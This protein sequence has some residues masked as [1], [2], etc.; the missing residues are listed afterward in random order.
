MD[1]HTPG[2]VDREGWQYA[3]DFPATYH[4]KKQFTDYVRRRRWYRKCRLTT[5]G[6]WHELGNSKICDVSLQ[7][8]GPS[9]SGGS[10]DGAADDDSRPISVWAIAG[11]GDALWR[12]GCTPATPAG[13]S[14]DHV[15]SH[16]PL[17]SISCAAENR[18]WVVSKTGTAFVRYGVT[19]DQPQGEAWQPVE[20]PSGTT[21]KQIS[22]GRMGVW[23]LDSHGRLVVRREVTTAFPEGTHWTVLANVQ[24]DGPHTE[25]PAPGATIGFKAVSVGTEVWAIANSGQLCRRAGIT[26]DNPAGTGW[27]LG[28]PVSRCSWVGQHFSNI[29][30]YADNSLINLFS[31]NPIFMM[32]CFVI[33]VLTGKLP[34]CVGERTGLGRIGF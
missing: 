3:I 7:P 12:R 28:I 15:A 6:P 26:S 13:L 32:F 2:G 20:P 17:V 27:L 14:W 9:G 31:A 18:V 24:G 1:F 8:L 10:G 21:L 33:N 16:Q 25:V 29:S 22:A 34:A 4:G 23:A 19:A 5:N 30:Q 11:N